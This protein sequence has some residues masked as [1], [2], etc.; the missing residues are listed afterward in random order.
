MTQHLVLTI[1]THDQPNTLAQLTQFLASH[2]C[3]IQSS[4]MLVLGEEFAMLIL[5]NGP[6]NQIAKLETHLPDF[7]TKHDLT[8]QFKRTELHQLDK[9]K[10][11]PYSVEL[12][13]HDSNGIIETICSFFTD[14]GAVIYEVQNNNYTANPVGIP[15]F[16]LAMRILVPA[17]SQLSDLRERFINI[18]DFLNVDAYLEPERA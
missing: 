15:M 10:W 6:W 11:I 5:I 17:D 16:S 8:V 7:A 13:S 4:R 9:K 12:I 3:Q 2:H 18:C 14:A 1:L